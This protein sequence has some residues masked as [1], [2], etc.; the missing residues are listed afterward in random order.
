LRS[1]SAFSEVSR[2]HGDFALVGVA[3]RVTLDASGVCESAALVLTGV[4]AA[5]FASS[6]AVQSLV[7]SR[8]SANDL[9]EAGRLTAAHVPA[10]SDIHASAAYRAHAAGVLTTRALLQAAARARARACSENETLPG[11]VRPASTD[12]LDSRTRE[13]PAATRPS[14]AAAA[15]SKH[16]VRLRVNGRPYARET[17]PRKLLV[18]FLRD[19]LGLTG[20]H[21][22]CE[23]G[24]CGA[25]TIV[26][27]G[28]AVRS[29]LQF[30]VQANDAEIETVEG[31]ATGEEL[32]VLQ[33]TFREHHA[34]Q[35]G[36]CT[37]GIL[38][39][40]VC[41]LREF[42]H[43]TEE[44]IRIA[45]AGNLCRCTGYLNIVRAVQ[46]AAGRSAQEK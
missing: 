35:C 15:L 41:F 17:E 16:T 3:A 38:M 1:G 8:L 45:L 40:F 23:H 2:R 31:L 33:Q 19:D 42:P 36:F 5:P 46:A 32:H 11:R 21:V 39:S 30:A 7:G 37:P 22:G 13:A 10:H 44:Q 26:V 4:G 29:C 34:L 25:C 24:I 20:T 18:D 9:S 43:P 6:A 27:N 14:P 28:E 12:G